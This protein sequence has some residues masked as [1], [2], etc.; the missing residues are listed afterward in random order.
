M[1]KPDLKI[2]LLGGSF[3]P[4]HAGHFEISQ[5]ALDRLNLDYVWWLVSPGNPL[6][7]KDDMASFE[8]RQK[9]ALEIATD[10]RIIVTDIEKK[11]K[12]RYTIDTLLELT[13]IHPDHHFVWL[14]GA[15]NLVQFDQWKDWKKI[16]NTLPFAIFSRPSYSRPSLKS[17]AAQ[18]LNQYRI[19]EIDAGKLYELKPPAWVY[20]FDSDNPTSS[21]EIRNNIK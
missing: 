14:M 19:D 4:A 6:K 1:D 5:T 2:G 16:A 17:P 3:N 21:T 18:Y 12:T 11:L 7:S 13:K 15:D 8:V 10:K 9:S 20:C